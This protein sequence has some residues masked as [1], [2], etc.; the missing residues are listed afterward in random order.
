M[1]PVWTA[2]RVVSE[3]LARSLIEDQFPD[4]APARVEPLGVGWDNT[5]Y[6]VN[7]AWVFRFPRRSIAVPLLEA[8]ASLLPFLAGRLPLAVPVPTHVGRPTDEFPWPFIGHRLIPGRTACG[9]G[10]GAEARSAAAGPLGRFLAALH[11]VPA[12]EAAARGAGPDALG[13]LDTARRIPKAHKDLAEI[14][15]RGLVADP[16]PLA[17]ALDDVPGGHVLR[18]D[19]LVHGDLYAR[20]LLVDEGGRLAGVID[21]GDVHLGD[22]AVDLAVA[23]AFLP[24]GARGA[25]REAYGPV[26]DGTWRL[27]RLRALWHT[28]TV[29]LYGH[30]TGD[31]DLVREAQSG[32]SF[33][34]L[35]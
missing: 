14:I 2:E 27:A 17:A 8:E 5:A 4:L 35:A 22:P 32:L 25:F 13:R 23:Q 1:N 20:H 19:T 21:W 12:A 31:A 18:T 29:L 15:R 24:P 16:R 9:A 34:A 10:L 6:V 33:L 30:D 28:M 3:A 7:D 11:A 26:D